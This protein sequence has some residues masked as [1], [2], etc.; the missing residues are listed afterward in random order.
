MRLG[1]RLAHCVACVLLCSIALGS[2][3]EAAPPADPKPVVQRWVGDDGPRQNSIEA[4]AQTP[5]GYLWLGTTAGLL[6]FDGASFTRFTRRSHPALPH[7]WIVSLVADRDGRLWVGTDNGLVV[8]ERGVISLPPTSIAPGRVNAL[9]IGLDGRVWSA[10]DAGLVAFPPRPTVTHRFSAVDSAAPRTLLAAADGSIWA[11]YPAR[12]LVRWDPA[13]PRLE[14]VDIPGLVLTLA[15]ASDGS[16]LIGTEAGLQRWRSN[17]I[18]SS[19]TAAGTHGAPVQAL[20]RRPDGTFLAA[21]G[22]E[23]LMVLGGDTLRAV[24]RVPELPLSDIRSL[25]VDGEGNTW[26]G[27]ET[28]GLARVSTGHVRRLDTGSD[29]AGGPAVATFQ[30]TGRGVWVAERCAGVV[31]LFDGEPDH[32]L[33]GEGDLPNRCVWTLSEHPAGTMW[34]GTWGGGAMRYERRERRSLGI[35]DAESGADDTILALQPDAAGRM[36]IGSERGVFVYE[37]GGTVRRQEG[38]EALDGRV[39]A[40]HEAGDGSMWIA[41]DTGVF[42]H[43][44]GT[45]QRFEL[46]FARAIAADGRDG[47]LVSTYGRGLHHIAADHQIRHLGEPLGLRDDFVSHV[48]QDAAGY[49]WITGN[50][51]VVSFG[52]ERLHDVLLQREGSLDPMW[53]TA[54]DG[55]PSSECNGGS[56]HSAFIDREGLL[57]VPTMGGVGVIDTQGLTLASRRPPPV[58]VESITTP[59]RRLNTL[60]PEVTVLLAADERELE[61][62]YSAFHYRAPDHLRFRYRLDNGPWKDAGARRVAIFTGLAPGA[63]TFVVEAR[64]GQGPWSNPATLALSAQPRWYELTWLR[65]AALI[66]TLL[67]L[68]LIARQVRRRRFQVETLV[69]IR[70]HELARANAQLAALANVDTLT[71]V[72]S[73][74]HFEERLRFAWRTAE[75]TRTTISLLMIDVDHFKR[76]N[77]DHGHVAGDD[78]L[79]QLSSRLSARIKRDT[80]TLA[81]YGGEEFVVLLPSTDTRGALQVAEALHRA[82]RDEPLRLG[83]SARDARVTVS[84]GVATRIPDIGESPTSL[85]DA[86][87]RAMYRAKNAGRDRVVTDSIELVRG[88]RAVPDPESETSPTDKRTTSR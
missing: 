21:L 19:A 87:D 83:D 88:L 56:Q 45:T 23:G 37:A 82:I 51:G 67:G 50:S 13:R 28:A 3:A 47:W 17:G 61:I 73:R 5:D 46:P 78:A 86:A 34:F 79:V 70:T 44:V 16:V 49:F 69:E 52:V 25:L 57:Y 63:H 68:A 22:G 14:H 58:V 72:G 74:R 4:I 43:Q 31:R 10:G 8:V 29:T 6:R 32:R 42:R 76:L 38:L 24:R 11:G 54:R 20:V 7:D 85:I 55:L 77:D 36:W 48:L 1:V 41:A 75:R 9:A 33:T 27:F 12:G 84:V 2:T 59:G 60:D 15:Q 53:L 65:L 39:R 64:V 62:A 35:I 80:D 81:R 18:V 40:F 66:L 71:G 30:D 26:V